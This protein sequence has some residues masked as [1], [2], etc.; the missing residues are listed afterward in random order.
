MEVETLPAL[1]VAIFSSGGPLDRADAL[2]WRRQVP[3][4][5]A[6]VYGSTESGGIAW[7]RQGEAP[8]S[9][10]WTPLADAGVT[11]ALDGALVVKSFRAGPAP[12][13]ME[14]GAALNPDGTFRLLGRLDRTIKLEEKRISLPELEAALEA[15]PLVA[16]AAVVLLEGA[17]PALGAVIK[18]A[19]PAGVRKEQV[20]ALRA[21]LARRFEPVALP[22]RW[23][24]PAELP[25]DARG[26]LTPGALAALFAPEGT[27]P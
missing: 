5:V 22:R 7:R 2:S 15:H 20:E 9:S 13:R 24:F 6:E 25:Y 1:P 12:L 17:R 19:G 4:G 14:D 27:R 21:H 23:R 3:S 16:R 18:L 8:A 10:F 11:L 26:K